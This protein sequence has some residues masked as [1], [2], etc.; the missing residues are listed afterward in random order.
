MRVAHRL[1]RLDAEQ[2][3]LRARI[4]VRQVMAIVGRDQRNSRFLRKAHDLGIYAL[5]DFQPLI[6]NFEV[7]IVFAENIPQTIGRLARLIGFSSTSPS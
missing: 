1:A 6:L 7:E 3:F 2:D 5:L 4:G